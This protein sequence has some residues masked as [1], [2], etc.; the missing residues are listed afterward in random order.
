MLCIRKRRQEH[1]LSKFLVDLEQLQKRL[2]DKLINRLKQ[3]N[4]T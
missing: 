3:K 2:L 4:F 1:K